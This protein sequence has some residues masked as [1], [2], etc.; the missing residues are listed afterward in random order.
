MHEKTEC[1]QEKG[2]IK[3]RWLFAI[4]LGVIILLDHFGLLAKGWFEPAIA[5]LLILYGLI[6]LMRA[7]R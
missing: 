4:V 5:G 7:T 1:P 3:F 6:G 2:G